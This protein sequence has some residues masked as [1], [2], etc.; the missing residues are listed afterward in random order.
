MRINQRVDEKYNSAL[1]QRDRFL[2]IGIEN[3]INIPGSQFMAPQKTPCHFS[4]MQG[5]I[6]KERDCKA[7]TDKPAELSINHASLIASVDLWQTLQVPVWMQNHGIFK[8]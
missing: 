3:A 2:G 8:K 5:H 1:L 7:K 6:A 4:P